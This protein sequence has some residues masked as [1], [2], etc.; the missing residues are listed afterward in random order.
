MSLVKLLPDKQR[1]LRI[2]PQKW[3]RATTDECSCS[4]G[5]TVFHVIS[6]CPQTKLEDRLQWLHAADNVAVQL[7]GLLISDEEFS[8][9]SPPNIFNIFMQLNIL[10]CYEVLWMLFIENFQLSHFIRFSGTFI[11]IIMHVYCLL[12]CAV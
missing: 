5:Q 2:L 6:S 3:G 12:I 1:S 4:K 9:P 7:H 11:H 10:N 8:P